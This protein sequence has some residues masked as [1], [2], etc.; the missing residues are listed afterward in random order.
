MDVSRLILLILIVG[1]TPLLNALELSPLSNAPYVGDLDQLKKKGTVRVLVSADLG[2]YFIEDGKPK[3]IIAEMLYHFEKSLKKKNPYLNVQIIPV[4][5]DD[6]LPSLKSGYGDVAVANLTITDKRLKVIDFANPMIQNGKEL[7]ITGL[8]TESF[9]SIEQLSGREVWIRASSSYFESIQRVNEE[10]NKKGLP[11]V[12]VHFIEE[13]LQDYELI[14]LVNQ[15]YIESTILDSHKARLWLNVMD[16]I[17]IHESLP[18]RENS[19]IAWALRKNSPQLKKEI[20][21][22]VK[23]ARS[24]TLLGNVIYQ[25]YIDNT[26]WLSRVLNPKK[27]DRVANL[28]EVFQ[29]YSSKYEFDPLMMSAQGFQESGLDQS[30]VS[31]KGAIGVMQVLPSTARDKNVNIPNIH[32]V[33]NNIHAGIKYMRF[34]KDRYFND[35]AISPDDQI[36]FTLAAYNAGPAKIR[37]M[38]KLAKTKGYNPNVWFKNVEIITRKYVSKEPVTYVTNINRYYVIY[39]QL[40]AIQAI[41]GSGNARLLK[42]NASFK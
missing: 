19:K 7:F 1:F 30:R 35:E 2:F 26:R 13:S 10:L 34:I 14:E 20:N 23:T 41:K 5:R 39:K 33:D 8:K 32:K 37:K 3:G 4:Q 27:V 38:R 42:N 12:Y 6:L 18:L 24:G 36:Y 11:P 25:K 31:H 16:N 17:Q 9:T 22:Y 40:E 15:G 21:K 29:K 28:S